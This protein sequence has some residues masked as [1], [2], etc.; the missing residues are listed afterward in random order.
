MIRAASHGQY[1]QQ[2]IRAGQYGG[3]TVLSA[4]LIACVPQ[5]FDDPITVMLDREADDRFRRQAAEQAQTLGP[6]NKRYIQA[7]NQ[8]LWEP[9]YSQWQ[10]RYAVDRLVEFD[11]VRFRQTLA[12]RITAIPSWDTRR[13]IFDLAINREWTDFTA[14]AVQSYAQTVTGVPDHDRPERAVITFCNPGRSIE[15]AVAQVFVNASGDVSQTQQVAAW[16]FL[17]RLVDRAALI[18][19]LEQAPPTSPLIIDI[20][21][22]WTQLHTL[23]RNRE[24]VLWLAYLRDPARQAVW[25]HLA[26]VAGGLNPEQL[27]GLELRHLPVLRRLDATVMA[28]DDNTLKQRV[29]ALIEPERL[30][31]PP[32]GVARPAS[33]AGEINS[34]WLC[35]ADWAVI[36]LIARSLQ[37]R[38]LVQAL[39]A[40]ADADFN[41]KKSE[42][43]GVLDWQDG[44]IVAH[45]YEP[46]MRR[47]DRIFYPSPK[48]VEHL[49]TAVA[50]YHFHAQE[51]DNGEFAKPGRG[52][53]ELANRMNFNGLIFTFVSRDRLRVS[54]YQPNGAVVDLGVIVR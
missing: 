22:S 34:G 28:M 52:D 36:D 43:G 23:P 8:L 11:E 48:M 49:Y 14:P 33:G 17:N 45:S 47:H 6:Q 7:L 5:G 24:G 29:R 37:S 38:G 40:Q 26:A 39:F 15:Q 21:A 9:G 51:Y 50:H 46:M 10:R 3:L 35:W 32:S 2:V 27:Q 30:D 13:Y 1:F 44:E 20:K 41:D 54:Y 19:Q 18:Q 16:E 12:R 31:Y 42:H 4:L 25:N 53:L